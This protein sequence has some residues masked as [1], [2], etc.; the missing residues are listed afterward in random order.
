MLPIL[1]A[2]APVAGSLVK[3]L[4]TKVAS[5]PVVKMAAATA[6]TLGIT[7]AVQSAT[8]PQTLPALPAGGGLPALPGLQTQA[9]QQ[10]GPG[11][12]PVP[13]FKGPG[14]ALQMPWN[15][16]RIPQMLRQYS[17]DDAYLRPSVRAPRGYVVI[18]DASG[19]PYAVERSIAIKL[20]M[21]R[22]ARKP[23][24]SAGEWNQYKTAKRVA[25]KLMKIA[26]P[27]VRSRQRKAGAKNTVCFTKKRKA[28]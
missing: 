23:P 15:D 12:L 24:I 6:A 18:R 8:A 20:K 27:E 4:I 2:L 22:P 28:A 10:A 14:G 9:I 13:W 7:S 3:S 17:L 1:A 5:K 21:W 11:G 19:R 25:K 16:P 26:G